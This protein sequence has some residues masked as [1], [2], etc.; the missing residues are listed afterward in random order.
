MKINQIIPEARDRMY[1]YI[2][3]IVP[4]WP[5]Y[6][7]K[8]WLYASL[9]TGHTAGQDEYLQKVP[10]SARSKLYR[11]QY[12]PVDNPNQDLKGTLQ[13]KQAAKNIM[14]PSD[15]LSGKYNWT[16]ANIGKDLPRIID[17][18]G[19]S[20]DTKWQLVPNMKFTMDMWIPEVVAKL[21]ARAGGKQHPD[22]ETPRDAERHATQAQLAQ[23]Q[24]GVRKEPVIIVKRPD[25]YDLIEGWHRTIQHFH[26]FPDGYTGPAYVA[27]SS[28]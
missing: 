14:G 6:V 26:K 19:L 10:D 18:Q 8:D 25:G 13:A 9:A 16:F 15:E 4:T 21:N 23:Q 12:K 24:G 1:Q 11:Y 28:K 5:D 22:F 20:I 27:Q 7:V 3:S 2:K 17:A